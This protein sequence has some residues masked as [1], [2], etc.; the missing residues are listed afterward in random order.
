[1]N[2][3]SLIGTGLNPQWHGQ[4]EEARET[5]LH[6]RLPHYPS[7][8]AVLRRLLSFK[9]VTL[10]LEQGEGNSALYCPLL[11]DCLHDYFLLMHLIFLAHSKLIRCKNMATGMLKPGGTYQSE[12]LQSHS[13][14][15]PGLHW[16]VFISGGTVVNWWQ[17]GGQTRLTDGLGEQKLDL[18]TQIKFYSNSKALFIFCVQL[19][20]CNGSIGFNGADKTK[21]DGFNVCFEDVKTLT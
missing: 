10:L 21:W 2:A 16:A 9:T 15:I 3:G 8:S 4:R 17:V 6:S 13:C 14:H 7:L 11:P 5:P 18:V 12:H 20:G 19:L 1:M